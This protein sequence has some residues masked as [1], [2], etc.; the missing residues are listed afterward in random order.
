MEYLIGRLLDN[1]V[2]NFDATVADACTDLGL[3]YDAIRNSLMMV[4]VMVV[5]AV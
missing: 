4:L 3:D 1:I 5:W 2:V